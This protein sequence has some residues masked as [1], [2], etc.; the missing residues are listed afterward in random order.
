MIPESR[1]GKQGVV[2]ADLSGK[3]PGMTGQGKPR[4]KWKRCRRIS[5]QLT[6]FLRHALRQI[7][8]VRSRV[9]QQLLFIQGLRV[10]QRLLRGV[11][12][13]T[14]GVALERGQVVEPGRLFPAFAGFHRYD[15][16]FLATAQGGDAL[17]LRAILRALAFGREG[18]A[19]QPH[20][21]IGG[22]L[23]RGDIRLA[24]HQHGQRGGHHAPDVERPSIEQGKVAG[25]VDAHQPVRLCPAQG[26]L[27]QRIIVRGRLH[28]PQPLADGVFLHGGGPEPQDRLI[29]AR[30]IIDEAEDELALAPRVAGVDDLENVG[31]AHEAFERFKL[32]GALFNDLVPPGPW[33]DG[34]VLLPPSGVARIVT[35]RRGQFHQM[36]GAP[37]HQDVRPLQIAGLLLPDVQHRG[38]GLSNAGFFRY[39]QPFHEFPPS[40]A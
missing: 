28:L 11:A 38:N 39:N 10:V 18:A 35:L 27:P 37:A 7:P 13:Q 25:G 30:Q 24:L 6:R 5:S 36:S 34:Q 12:E 26:G 33:D 17:R 19:V 9:G 16:C 8:A 4:G 2:V 23:K 31:A 21:I 22:R 40:S 20:M 29:A 32:P 14:V 3:L 1:R 15:P